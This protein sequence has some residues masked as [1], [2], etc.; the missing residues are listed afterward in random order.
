LFDLQEAL[1]R[2][3]RDSDLA[4]R[5]DTSRVALIGHSLGGY[6]ALGAAGAWPGWKVPGVRAVIALSPYAEPFLAHRRLAALRVPVMYQGGT[7]DFT[8]TPYLLGD[9]GAYARSPAPKF[10]VVLAG[11]THLAWTNW[12]CGSFQDAAGCLT[13]DSIARDI[14]AYAIGFLD[15]YLKEIPAPLLDGDGR[16]LAEWKRSP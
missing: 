1:Q 14:D 3:E 11:A 6:T 2:V 12:L 8:I 7:L 9:A 4:S 10:L 13:N 5:I 16:N 15:R